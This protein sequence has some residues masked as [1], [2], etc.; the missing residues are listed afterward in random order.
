VWAW[1]WDIEE[2]SEFGN[3]LGA[4]DDDTLSPLEGCAGPSCCCMHSVE[5]DAKNRLAYVIHYDLC[6]VL[7]SRHVMHPTASDLPDPQS[8][9]HAPLS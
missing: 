8:P 7:P 4:S 6:Y 2:D 3:C 9:L 1:E 5:V